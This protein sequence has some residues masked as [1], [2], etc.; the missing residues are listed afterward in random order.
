VKN[1][2]DLTVHISPGVDGA[3]AVRV[4]TGNG[5]AA[6]S[7]LRL[8]FTLHDL[9][10]VVFGVAQTTRTVEELVEPEA[11]A[12]GPEPTASPN[13]RDFGAR[14]F[15]ALFQGQARDMLV[16][17]EA[18]ARHEQADGVR[19]RL[20]MDLSLTGMAEVA[21]LPWELM[22]PKDGRALAVSTKT[23]LVRSLDAAQPIAPRVFV[24]PLRILLVM[25]SPKGTA[26]LNLEEERRKI[27]QSWEQLPGVRVRSVRPVPARIMGALA[28]DDY[29]VVHY[30]GHGDFDAAEGGR[31]L[32]E[33]EDGS[34]DA[35][36][37]EVF[38]G[39]LEAEPLR[40]VFLNACK[41]GTTSTQSGALPFAG[42]AT[43][44]IGAGVPA[45]VAMQ[46]PISDKAAILFAT[47][48][49][50]RIA[51]RWPVDAAVTD[52]RKAL[53]ASRLAEW[54]TPV[55][56]L[57]SKDGHLFGP[58]TDS[59]SIAPEAPSSPAQVATTPAAPAADDP[60][61]PDAGSAFRVFLAS[62]DQNL[63][64]LH[65]RLATALRAL[66]AVRVVDSVPDDDPDTYTATVTALASRADLSVHLLGASPGKRL[67]DDDPP[68]TLKTVQLTQLEI[69]LQ[70]N[71]PQLVVMTS[72]DKASI[73][74]PAYE[75]E[76]RR[77][78]MV[79]GDRARYEPRMGIDKNQIADAVIDKVK[80]LQEARQAPSAASGRT[81]IV[82]AHP[83]DSAHAVDLLEYFEHRHVSTSVSTTS[84]A[85][86]KQIDEAVKKYSLCVIVSGQVER[87]WVS[88]RK[89]AVIK[90]ASKSRVPLLLS[91]YSVGQ[92]DG[93]SAV[94]ALSDRLNTEPLNDGDRTWLDALLVSAPETK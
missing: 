73:S 31:L 57:R 84:A 91:Q 2:L 74:N 37:G 40:L 36:S 25:S 61:G 67:D 41:T 21:S 3:Y 86:F 48:F 89:V 22:W 26:A 13:A 59:A 8:P 70:G 66:P 16:K 5:D 9:K 14:L 93:A 17:S 79:P 30:M 32:L 1:H 50:Q 64:G 27:E 62:P 90:S 39:M 54:A 53:Y 69:G 82:Y 42:V 12:G 87:D 49:Y 38:A 6:T 83:K 92:D 11:A 43:A 52:G 23:L 94:P 71:R 35:V 46:F 20:S 72:E 68:D 29:H 58:V 15:D 34:P 77:L 33:L 47:T 76:I 7:T 56:Y 63:S 65:R 44:L 85:D 24:P 80:T 81:A 18:L 51:L 45:V 19:V 10:G 4:V 60:W 78:Q 75:A 55:L 88:S 28:E